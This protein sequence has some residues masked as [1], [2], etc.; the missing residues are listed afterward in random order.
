M[1][2]I[3]HPERFSCRLER[4]R[5][6]ATPLLIFIERGILRFPGGKAVRG[7]AV[8]IQRIHAGNQNGSLPGMAIADPLECIRG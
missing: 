3:K 5:S 4:S 8:R 6:F 7:L 2:L 1:R